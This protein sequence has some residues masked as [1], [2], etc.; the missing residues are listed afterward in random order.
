MIARNMKSLTIAISFAF[1]IS[2]FVFSP[3]VD[4]Q[5]NTENVLVSLNGPSVV[6]TLRVSTYSATIIDAENRAWDYKVFITSKSNMTGASPLEASPI[7][8]TV[9]PGNNTFSFEITAPQAKGELNIHINCTSGSYYYTKIHKIFVVTPISLSV[10]VNNPTNVEIKNATVQ[11]F[12][13]GNEIDKQVLL[14]IGAGQ[15]TKVSSEWISKDKTPGWHTSKILIDM[16]GDGT[17]DTNMGDMIVNDRF[18]IEGSADWMFALT[19][20]VGL[21]ALIIGFGYLSKRKLK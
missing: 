15:S 9:T 1:I 20:L 2:A 7:N 8:G 16:N 14:S 21:T 10:E 12:V 3:L 17:I 11:F 19:I 13:D 18:Y 6:G 4:A 5:T